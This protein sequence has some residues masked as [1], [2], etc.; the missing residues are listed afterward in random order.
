MEISNPGNLGEDVWG[1]KNTEL[2]GITYFNF[3]VG[4]PYGVKY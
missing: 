3:H 4:I 2:S 1:N